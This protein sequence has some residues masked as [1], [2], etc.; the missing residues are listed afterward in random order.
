MSVCLASHPHVVSLIW[1]LPSWSTMS[2]VPSLVIF[3]KCLNV[4][5]L[6]RYR[7]NVSKMLS[8]QMLSVIKLKH[9]RQCEHSRAREEA[10][11]LGPAPGGPLSAPVTL[12]LP[13]TWVFAAGCPRSCP[14]SVLLQGAESSERQSGIAIL[15]T[16]F[17]LGLRRVCRRQSAQVFQ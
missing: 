17:V 14:R 2:S 3:K 6:L 11:A 1:Q 9:R 5:V 8:E 16:C 4:V 10:G 15:V 13:L 7:K 12:S